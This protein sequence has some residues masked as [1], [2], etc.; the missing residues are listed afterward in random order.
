MMP[1]QT[2]DHYS[3]DPANSALTECQQRV[4]LAERLETFAN[5]LRTFR[6]A[7]PHSVPS[8]ESLLYM[9]Q[10]AY[11][12]RRHIDRVFSFDG[13]AVSPAWDILLDLYQARAKGRSESVSSASIGAACPPTTALRW[14]QLLEALNLIERSADPHD[15][16]RTFVKLTEASVVRIERALE[17]HV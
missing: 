4:V 12:A 8:S 11:A 1:S 2:S 7:K 10:K 16:R 14:L 3:V 17:A 6:E 5:E 15:K 9:A 13:F